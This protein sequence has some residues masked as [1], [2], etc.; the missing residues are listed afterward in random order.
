M[1]RRLSPIRRGLAPLAL[2]ATGVLALGACGGSSGSPSSQGSEGTSDGDKP[3]S[4]SDRPP[5]VPLPT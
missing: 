1:H 3:V 5:P 2:L 4:G